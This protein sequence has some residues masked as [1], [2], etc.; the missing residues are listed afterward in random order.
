MAKI[1]LVECWGQK[2]DYTMSKRE[3]MEKTSVYTALFRSL[4][5]KGF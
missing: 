3:N 1:V 2:P 5:V 4:T